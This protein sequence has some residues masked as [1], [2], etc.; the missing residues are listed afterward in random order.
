MIAQL[1]SFDVYAEFT[2]TPRADAVNGFAPANSTWRTG[3]N[4]LA[5]DAVTPYFVAKD[6]G[7]QYLSTNASF[8]QVIQP[9]VTPVQ[10]EGNFTLSTI[11]IE[12]LPAN[13]TAKEVS[14]AGHAAFEVLEGQLTVEMEGEELGL[15]TGDVVFIPGGTPYTYYSKVAY[16]KF[17][18]ISQG[19]EGLDTSLIAGGST[20]SSPVWPTS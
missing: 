9:F 12:S 6:Y 7:P 10:S 8:Y 16:T 11:T 15:S 18:Q 2:Y 4:A 14:F 5:T 13:A 3:T 20:W 1:T 19:A 17:L